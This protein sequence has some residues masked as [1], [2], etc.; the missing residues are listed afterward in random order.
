MMDYIGAAVL[1]IFIIA[2]LTWL[3]R[4]ERRDRIATEG[5]LATEHQQATEQE[6]V[7]EHQ[8]ATEEELS[9]E[10]QRSDDHG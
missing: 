1:F 3:W 2:V 4:R 10:G 6:L 9:S 8:Q 5:K 7:T